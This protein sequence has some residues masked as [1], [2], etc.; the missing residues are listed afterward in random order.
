MFVAE[1][2]DCKVVLV[3][4]IDRGGV[5]AA[6]VGTMELLDPEER[7]RVGALLVNKFRGDASLLEPGL[8]FVTQRTGVPVLGVLP[9]VHRLRVADEDSVELEARRGRGRAGPDEVEIAVVRL[10]HISNY[11]DFQPLEHEP[12]VVVRF[13]EDAREIGKPEEAGDPDLVVL[14]GT[15]ATLADLAWLRASGLADAVVARAG[16]GRPVL[17]VCGGCQMLG[18]RIDDPE[19]AESRESSAPGL[20]LLPVTTRFSP[21]KRTAQVRARSIAASFLCDAREDVGA[22]EIHMGRVERRP[23]HDGLFAIS[24]RNGA[25]DEGLDGAVGAGGAV[26]GTMLHGLFDNAPVRRALVASLRARRGLPAAG[27]A[28]GPRAPDE[29]DRLADVL[30]ASVDVELLHRLLG[31]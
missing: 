14:P 18:E 17:G 7:A 24:A 9:F 10:P 25:P 8:R 19:H 23:G 22:Y 6:F 20:G 15:K 31:R 13:V 26:L 21:V 16:R 5:F 12:G 4:D 2:A 28:P 11:D 30:R 3:G 27:E 29:F 1:A